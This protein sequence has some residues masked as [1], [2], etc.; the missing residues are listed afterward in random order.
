VRGVFLS[1]LLLRSALSDDGHEAPPQPETYL[2]RHSDIFEMPVCLKTSTQIWI[3]AI[4]WPTPK[5]P[6]TLSFSRTKMSE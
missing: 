5:R 1:T 6:T 3:H 4:D 2:V